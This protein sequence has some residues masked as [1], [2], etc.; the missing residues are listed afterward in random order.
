M[1]AKVFDLS[2]ILTAIDNISA[3]LNKASQ[4]LNKFSSKAGKLSKKMKGMGDKLTRNV[5][6]PIVA[7]GALSS[8]TFMKFDD[9]MKAVQA[10]TGATGKDLK[11][12]TDAAKEM[13]QTT[14]FRASEAAEGMNFLAMA[15]F[16]TNKII[17]SMPAMLDLAAASSMGL[18]Q[19]ADMTSDIMSQFNLKAEDSARVSNVLA[20][21]SNRTNTDVSQMFEAFKFAGPVFAGL[22]VSIEETAT[23]IGL[24]ADKGLKGGMATRALTTAFTKLSKPSKDAFLLMEEHGVKAFDS[25][26]KFKGV[27]NV[28]GETEEAMKGMTEEQ[29][30]AF[31]STIFGSESLKSLN[32][33]L[34]TNKKIMVDGKE[35]NLKGTAALR[36]FNNELIKSKGF[37]KKT[38]EIMESGFG[39]SMRRMFSAV[40]GFA[41][42]I[43]KI[44][45]PMITKV[46]EK[47]IKLTKWFNKLSP[48]T[49]SMIVKIALLAAALGP[50]LIIMAKLITV[51]QTIAAA[52]AFLLANPMVLIVAGI[53]LLI[54]GITKLVLFLIKIER[55]SKSVSR[56]FQRLGDSIIKLADWFKKLPLPLKALIGAFAPFLAIPLTLIANWEKVEE[57]ISETIDKIKGLD[58]GSKIKTFGGGIAEK[59]T[60]FFGGNKSQTDVNITVS[61]ESGSSAKVTKVKNKNGNLNLKNKSGGDFGKTLG[62]VAR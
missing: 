55:K 50:A 41:I 13:G 7:M 32:A 10:R 22:G 4:K 9:S 27:I 43:G 47:I 37:A 52:M 31:K 39:G 58:L 35:V 44:L 6:L 2:V 36:G 19:A 62:G 53:A 16:D 61:A 5:T 15:G 17:K 40:E 51:L 14:R 54:F 59:V 26:G 42:T 38:A 28:L 12:L 57:T 29:A 60:G 49:K 24:L 1:A 18:A 25:Q 46:S 45:A 23:I 20:K 8:R 56:F 3:P 33:L 11:R 30:L 34:D 21:T 48:S